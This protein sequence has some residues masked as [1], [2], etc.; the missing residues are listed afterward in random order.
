MHKDLIAY[1]S[2]LSGKNS[3]KR[4]NPLVSSIN[5]AFDL[6]FN[7][8]PIVGDDLIDYYRSHSELK[9]FTLKSELPRM[10]YEVL[11]ADINAKEGRKLVTPE[12]IRSYFDDADIDEE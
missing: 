8:N 2:N 10:D 12:E 1:F 9:E 7:A 11:V 4:G 5:D 6:Q 3:N